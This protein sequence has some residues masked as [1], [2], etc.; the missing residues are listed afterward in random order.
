M[1]HDLEVQQLMHA[2]VMTFPMSYEKGMDS[3][4]IAIDFFFA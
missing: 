2:R 1:C 4:G 3:S